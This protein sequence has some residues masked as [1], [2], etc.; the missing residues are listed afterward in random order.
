MVLGFTGTREGMTDKQKSVVDFI[1]Q[2][3]APSLVRHGDCIG[4]DHDFHVL[5]YYRS[6]LV[7]IH[8]P[9]KEEYRARCD[10]LYTN[11]NKVWTPKPYLDRDRDIVDTSTALVATPKEYKNKL[12]SGTWYTFRYAKKVWADSGKRIAIVFP[13]GTVDTF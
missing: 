13:D 8:P 1:L 6:I 7:D 4:A 9:I 12:R 10:R 2:D 11:I 5:A 3:W